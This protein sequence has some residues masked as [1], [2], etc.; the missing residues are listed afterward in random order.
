MKEQTEQ[1]VGIDVS[2]ADLDVY[3]HPEAKQWCSTNNELGMAEIAKV[4]DSVEV[5][6]V[7]L[8][9]TGGTHAC[10]ES[11]R[12][13]RGVP[14]SRAARLSARRSCSGKPKVRGWGL[15]QKVLR[16]NSELDSEFTDY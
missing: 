1:W 10:P 8:E 3:L 13:S 6:L 16:P 12:D 15:N 14:S 5:A 2:K 7:V 4:L 9:A 11:G